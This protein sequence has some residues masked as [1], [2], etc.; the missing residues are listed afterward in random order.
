MKNTKN[1]KL[2]S[3]ALLLLSM[4]CSCATPTQGETSSSTNSGTSGSVVVSTNSNGETVEI[5]LNPL[6]YSVKNMAGEIVSEKELQR[7]L[8][9]I[10]TNTS[11]WAYYE[12]DYEILP[13]EDTRKEEATQKAAM[14][15]EL[16]LDG[17]T[18]EGLTEAEA[19]EQGILY[20]AVY[21]SCFTLEEL[22]EMRKRSSFRVKEMLRSLPELNWETSEACAAIEKFDFM[23]DKE[24]YDYG[25]KYKH[26]TKLFHL[27]LIFGRAD[28]TIG[29]V[30]FVYD[31][32]I[33]SSAKELEEMAAVLES[34]LTHFNPTYDDIILET[35][36]SAG[37]NP[38]DKREDRVQR[39]PDLGGG[40]CI[41]V[42]GRQFNFFPY[43]DWE[44]ESNIILADNP[45][46]YPYPYPDWELENEWIAVNYP[47]QTTFEYIPYNKIGG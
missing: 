28:D 17:R 9:E 34:I 12:F 39:F 47:D 19:Y 35:I 16:W 13:D 41:R 1:K 2:M 23:A 26:Q 15:S 42:M 22:L 20:S 33:F 24:V 27:T 43:A 40:T 7:A 21:D 37:K 44:T 11:R 4:L 45:D 3:L 32:T 8:A 18:A 25:I 6:D 30:M 14:V 10:G 46:V 38:E 36:I 31:S 29:S 5:S